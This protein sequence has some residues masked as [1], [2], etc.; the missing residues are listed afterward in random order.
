MKIT[1]LQQHQKQEALD[2]ALRVFMAFEAPDYDEEGVKNFNEFILNKEKTDAL[3]MY[4]AYDEGRLVG[5]GATRN[6]G[7]HISLL[8]VDTEFHGQ[9]IGRNLV[10]AMRRKCPEPFITVN[11]SPYAVEI[12]KKI[13]FVATDDELLSDGIRYTPMQCARQQHLGTVTIET[14]RL[15]L[16]R[17]TAEDATAMYE[18]WA[19]DL[20]VTKYLTWAPHLSV[21]ESEAVLAEWIS[22]Y[23]NQN[24]Y[25]WAITLKES[26]DIPI[27][28]I[29]AV[30]VD[31]ALNLAH[32]GYCIGRS[33]WNRGFTSE[34]LTA[35]IDF[36]LIKVGFNRVESRHDPNNPS[37][38][39]VM[40]KCGMIYEGTHQQAD[41]SNRGI[42]DS[43]WYGILAK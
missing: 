4:G 38:G 33:W 7:K 20:E 17:F 15:I 36:F 43:A 1:T 25:H 6:G 19:K 41:L 32:I 35:L 21:A 28:S 24:Y 42:C 18:N 30:R 31:D 3:A 34:A 16:R 26:P 11:S 10:E 27:G 29:G 39:R 13:G 22:L 40:Q 2:L 14:S 5:M 37:S 12:Y 9:G 23:E 8:F